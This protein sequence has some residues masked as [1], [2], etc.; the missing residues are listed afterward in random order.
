MMEEQSIQRR[1]ELR[2]GMRTEMRTKMRMERR[3]DVSESPEPPDP[4]LPPPPCGKAN[5]NHSQEE[6]P[7]H[8]PSSP[9]LLLTDSPVEGSDRRDAQVSVAV[10]SL[11][12]LGPV[13]PCS[14]EHELRSL[15]TS[16]RVT[17]PR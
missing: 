3:T 5:L 11:G 16:S 6:C 8:T 2:T 1:T 12:S 15:N 7:P 9:V 10:R 13:G 17:D 14:G 4:G